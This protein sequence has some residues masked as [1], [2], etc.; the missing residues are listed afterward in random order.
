MLRLSLNL[1]LARVLL[2]SKACGMIPFHIDYEQLQLVSD[3]YLTNQENCIAGST[4]TRL[5]LNVEMGY[6]ECSS[7]GL[8]QI[9]DCHRHANSYCQW[10]RGRRKAEVTLYLFDLIRYRPLL[11]FQVQLQPLDKHCFRALYH[12]LTQVSWDL[13]TEN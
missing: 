13:C 10:S 7:N 5:I 9:L 3:T 12:H 11:I 6:G 8:F 2:P 1:C 4:P